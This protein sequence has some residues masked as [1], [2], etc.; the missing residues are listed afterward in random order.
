[1]PIYS[2]QCKKCGTERT[3]IRLMSE[4]E[5]GPDCDRCRQQMKLILS[6]TPGYVKNPAVA[7]A[8]K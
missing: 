7:R 6:P 4:R 1:M 2:Y 8:F 5:D 3:N